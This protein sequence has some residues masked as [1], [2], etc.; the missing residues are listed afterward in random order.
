MSK[1][2]FTLKIT[3]KT[4]SE[5][6]ETSDS[7][8]QSDIS[9]PLRDRIAGSFG[10][11]LHNPPLGRACEQ[12]L[13]QYLRETQRSDFPDE[14]FVRFY[15][16]KAFN[17]LEN[18]DPDGSVENDYLNSKVISGEIS[19]NKLVRL[20]NQDLYP[21]KWQRIK[22]RRLNEIK[23]ENKQSQAT[24]D[25]YTCGKCK[26][27]ECTFFQMQTRSGDEPMTT[28]ITCV[29]CGKKWKE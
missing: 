22:E 9:D 28:F 11:L 1:K 3:K 24:T 15:Q 4:E 18:L 12:E 17:L 2:K 8:I 13:Y 20:S 6:S 10:S 21:V 16:D 27:R 5:C 25:L 29:N 23:E 26:K 19:P 7:G 14:K